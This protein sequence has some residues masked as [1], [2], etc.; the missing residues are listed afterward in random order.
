M[1]EEDSLERVRA[2]ID[3]LDEEILRLVNER[4]AA[5]REVARVKRESGAPGDF[6]RPSREVE[7]LNRIRAANP[8]PLPDDDV[9]R[10]FREMMSSCLALQQPLRVAFL[11]PEGTFTQEASLKHFG[12][13]MRTLPLESVDAVF[14][15][16][17]SG[18]AD[19]GVV[20]VENST[21]GVVTHTL[22][23]FLTSHL[24]I[25]GEVEL[26][27]RH[28]LASRETELEGITKVFSHQQGLAQ[29]RVWLDNNLPRVERVPVSSTAEAARQASET[30]G[31]AAVASDVASDRYGLTILNP[32]IQDGATNTTRFLVLGRQSP[33][34]T[35]ED[36]TSVVIS[37]SNKP[38]GLAGLLA[39]LARYGLN[40]TRIESRP[41]R[42]AMWEYVFFIDI[43]GHAEDPTLKRALGEMQ[44]LASLLKVLGSYPRAEH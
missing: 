40:M 25:V 26:P 23:R 12:H 8:G 30:P 14:R 44:Q 28:N 3:A 35:G 29:C 19:Y 10:L 4:A 18:N 43:L 42:E 27:I 2:K 6:Y 37:R 34:P 20:P 22:D 16:V 13:G 11:G 41:S 17:E 39:P 38:G 24:Q 21:E 1:S 5:A 32:N 31:A 15:E 33:P 9:V 7:V 36:K